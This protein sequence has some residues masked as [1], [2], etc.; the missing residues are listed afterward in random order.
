ML[1]SVKLTDAPAA[2]AKLCVARIAA[3]MMRSLM[4]SRSI[5]ATISSAMRSVRVVSVSMLWTLFMSWAASSDQD[6]LSLRVTAE[7]ESESMLSVTSG[8]NGL[9][10]R[11]YS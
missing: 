5:S 3:A 1:R 8:W 4:S 2:V 6:V 10:S 7:T 11:S 9:D